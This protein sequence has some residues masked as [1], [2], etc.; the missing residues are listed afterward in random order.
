MSRVISCFVLFCRA[1]VRS[2]WQASAAAAAAAAGVFT[3]AEAF[4]SV[5]W[6]ARGSTSRRILCCKSV[7]RTVPQ[8]VVCMSLRWG[9]YRGTDSVSVIATPGAPECAMLVKRPCARGA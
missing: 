9:P 2:G 4:F 5:R 1:S 7:L 3:A 6:P 8:R